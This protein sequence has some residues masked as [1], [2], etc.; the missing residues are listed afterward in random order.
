MDAGN[1]REITTEF[2]LAIWNDS[3]KRGA[4]VASF[5]FHSN[6]EKRSILALYTILDG[7]P[8]CAFPGI[9]PEAHRDLSDSLTALSVSDFAHVLIAKPLRTFVRH[10][11]VAILQPFEDI[12]AE[13]RGE[14]AAGLAAV[15]DLGD[16]RCE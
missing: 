8:P 6:G 5:R 7:K 9:A 11:L 4:A 14:V 10:P 1:D 3:V 2:S 13:G 12:E 15:I 16:Q